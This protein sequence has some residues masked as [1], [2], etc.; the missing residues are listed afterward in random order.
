MCKS[1]YSPRRPISISLPYFIEIFSRL[2]LSRERSGVFRRMLYF[3]L[4]LIFYCVSR[5]LLDCTYHM[6]S[7]LHGKKEYTVLYVYVTVCTWYVGKIL[8]A[9][10]LFC[11]AQRALFFRGKN[12][13]GVSQTGEKREGSKTQLRGGIK[14]AF[15]LISFSIFSWR[16]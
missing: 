7:S 4:Q 13:R 16:G 9:A 1:Q 8:L 11:I 12:T 2:K 3:F 15:N 6:S 14:Q 5:I 10:P